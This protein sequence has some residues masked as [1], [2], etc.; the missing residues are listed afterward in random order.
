MAGVRPPVRP[1]FPSACGQLL[2]STPC[3]LRGPSRRGLPRERRR[4]PLA[5]AASRW[6]RAVAGGRDSRPSGVPETSGRAA[7]SRPV[8]TA[9][10][11]QGR[12][13]ARAEGRRHRRPRL[14][15][16]AHRRGEASAASGPR[17]A[18]AQ[19]VTKVRQS[20]QP[21]ADWSVQRLI[22]RRR[23]TAPANR[24][25]ARRRFGP[26]SARQ[27]ARTDAAPCLTSLPP[28]GL[29]GSL[30]LLHVGGCAAPA[31]SCHGSPRS[32]GRPLNLVSAFLSPAV[33]F[34][35]SLEGFALYCWRTPASRPGPPGCGAGGPRSPA[36]RVT[37]TDGVRSCRTR[38]R[39]GLAG[40]TGAAC[41]P[42]PRF[43]Q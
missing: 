42:T 5:G 24:W 19:V 15:H 7:V 21:P 35:P 1:I 22:Q 17:K 23:W 6:R 26:P 34:P 40:S 4:A 2:R 25:A 30:Q 20:A 31:D 39:R 3:C 14:R 18:R 13:V 38:R 12:S 33:V 11:R 28:R 10:R 9:L 16:E 37:G 27:R 32:T 29:C 8:S 43:L 41:P 36:L